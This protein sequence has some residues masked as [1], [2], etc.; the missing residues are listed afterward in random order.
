MTA[1]LAPLLHIASRRDTLDIHVV[2]AASLAMLAVVAIVWMPAPRAFAEVR[3]R[4]HLP[5]P[6]LL[7]PIAGAWTLALAAQAAG[8]ADQL[9]H[10]QLIDGGVSPSMGFVLFLLAWQVMI[11]AMMLPSSLPLIRLFNRTAA[12]QPRANIVRASFLAGYV[13]VWTAFGAVAFGG[14][15]FV[16]YLVDHWAWLAG[17]TWLI[18]GG[19]LL[20]AGAFQFSD[21]K[22]KC[23]NECRHPSAYLMKHYRRGATEAF[24]MGR[25]HGVFCLG[26]CWALM[27]VAFAVGIANLA[28]MA[29]LTL[30]MLFEKTG[31]GGDRGVVPIGVT[32][33]ALGALVLLHPAWLPSLFTAT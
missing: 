23:L 12:S 17:R 22:D 11:A 20:I 24:R 14:D 25:T 8:R 6:S 15:I 28:W 29:A 3:E 5:Q 21:L 19:V 26:C 10:G 30:L 27:L 18:G 1:T 7:W 33:V 13:F 4:A 16:H 31:R 2:V 32:L 9:H